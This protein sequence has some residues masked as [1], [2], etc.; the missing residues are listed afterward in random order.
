VREAIT[1]D[2]LSGHVSVTVPF[3]FAV[4][5]AMIGWPP[6]HVPMPPVS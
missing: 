2:E 5:A 3:S 1:C 4:A 6:T